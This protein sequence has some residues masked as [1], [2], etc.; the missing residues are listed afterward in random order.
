VK[1]DKIYK[2]YNAIILLLPITLL[3]ISEQNRYHNCSLVIVKK[4]G[5]VS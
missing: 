5:I 2:I 1:V 3:L 4:I